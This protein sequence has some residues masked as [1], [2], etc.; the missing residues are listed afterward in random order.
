MDPAPYDDIGH[1]T[2]GRP[3][4]AM[5]MAN[6]RPSST[7]T[8]GSSYGLSNQSSTRSDG[9][10]QGSRHSGNAPHLPNRRSNNDGGYMTPADVNRVP[11]GQMYKGPSSAQMRH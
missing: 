9:S 6:T 3:G 8:T 2:A 7:S 10:H 5:E 1:A 11:Y 4:T